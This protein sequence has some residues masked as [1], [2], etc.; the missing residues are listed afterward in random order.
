MSPESKTLPLASLPEYWTLTLSPAYNHTDPY[1]TTGRVEQGHKDSCNSSCSRKQVVIYRSSLAAAVLDGCDLK[2]TGHHSR[3]TLAQHHGGA[4]A[5][6]HGHQ[7]ERPDEAKGRSTC[8]DSTS[9]TRHER[10][11]SK[12]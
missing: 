6:I 3:A 2:S 7:N 1:V 8:V 10:H 9:V 4:R 12:P 5:S 11:Y